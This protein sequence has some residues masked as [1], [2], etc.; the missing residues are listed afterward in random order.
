MQNQAKTAVVTGA[1]TGI[2]AGLVKTFLD[3]DIPSWRMPRT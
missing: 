2:G 3:E 1:S